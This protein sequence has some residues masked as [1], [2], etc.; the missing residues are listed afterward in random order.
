M[1]KKE[2]NKFFGLVFVIG[3]LL[4]DPF[5]SLEGSASN[6]V[7]ALSVSRAEIVERDLVSIPEIEAGQSIDFQVKY[8]NVSSVDW[9]SVGPNPLSLRNLQRKTSKFYDSSWYNLY[10][11][12]RLGKDGE[13]EVG[14]R[15]GQEVSF[16]FKLRAPEQP[17]LYWEK[18][19]LFLGA[20]EIDGSRIEIGIKV[21]PSTAVPEQ[22]TPTQPEEEEEEEEYYWQSVPA[23]IKIGTASPQIEEPEIKVGLFF[24]EE[25]QELPIKIRT[26]N[27]APYNVLSPQGDLLT[28]ATQG[29]E[30]EIDFDF[31]IERTFLNH[32]GQRI[33]M[34]DSYL[35]FVPVDENTIFEISSWNNGPFWGMQV[36]D[37]RFQGEIWVHYNPSTQRLW[38]IN[39]LPME[40]YVSGIHEVSDEAPFEFLKAQAIAARTYAYYRLID[41]KY[42]NTPDKSPH[43]AVLATQADQVYR[44]YNAFQRNPN[45]VKAVNETR[46][47][48]ATYNGNPILAYYFAQSDG[49]TRNSEEVNMTKDP[50]PY[51]KGKIDPPGQGK[52]LKGHG[53]GLPQ[54]SGIVAANQGANFSQILKYYYTG[55]ELTKF[56]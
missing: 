56:Y 44:G 55:I 45:F 26:L 35:R 27:N 37:N 53:V 23:E 19:A 13:A 22:P 10:T 20:E 29:D 30:L 38:V 47:I 11:P 15:P 32:Q 40:K 54:I 39:K 4:F 24:A 36:N 50:V 2:L 12:V 18:F 1:K 52:V 14:I 46:G 31:D 33:L 3:I 28:R 7:Y 43:F 48:I 41:P 42:T 16:T 9:L 5:L 21:K 49:R 25:E 6:R 34:T 8:K 51:L 17:G